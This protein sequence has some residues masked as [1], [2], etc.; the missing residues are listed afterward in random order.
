M[1]MYNA[2]QFNIMSIDN[3]TKIKM[4]LAFWRPKKGRTETY[5]EKA[6][7]KQ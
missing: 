3:R 1:D 4:C 7:K 5:T 2:K 6:K